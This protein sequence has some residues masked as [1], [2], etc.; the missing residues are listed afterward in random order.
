MRD[1]PPQNRDILRPLLERLARTIR[2]VAQDLLPLLAELT[3]A[4]IRLDLD[5]DAPVVV[6]SQ[7]RGGRVHVGK[8]GP[9]FHD[10]LC[11]EVGEAGG[12]CGGK[13]SGEVLTVAELGKT[14]F[15]RRILVLKI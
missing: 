6:G 4:E 3:H 8:D 15:G 10:D 13:L 5:L 11:A 9:V 12:I 7:V 14:V 2:R 1:E